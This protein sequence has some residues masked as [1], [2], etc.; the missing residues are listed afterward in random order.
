MTR[1]VCL[2]C[3][4]CRSCGFPQALIV[5]KHKFKEKRRPSDEALKR[6]VAEVNSMNVKGKVL[7][8][9]KEVRGATTDWAFRLLP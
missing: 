7:E 3:L 9:K 4:L 1:R 6:P 8:E 2:A 5:E